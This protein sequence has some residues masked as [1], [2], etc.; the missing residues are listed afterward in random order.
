MRFPGSVIKHV[1]ETVGPDYPVIVKM[2]VE[3]GFEGGLT[4]GEAAEAAKAFESA[5]ASALV[6]SCGFTARTS[7]YMMRG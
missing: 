3:D 1:R 7:F 4:I 6:P 2:N 5:G